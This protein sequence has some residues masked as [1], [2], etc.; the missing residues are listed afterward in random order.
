MEQLAQM[1][2]DL[3]EELTSLKENDDFNESQLDDVMYELD[4]L[5]EII[6]DHTED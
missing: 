5:K 4:G 1:I 2:D 6:K 3:M